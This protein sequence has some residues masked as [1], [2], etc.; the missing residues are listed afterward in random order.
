MFDTVQLYQICILYSVVKF[1]KCMLSIGNGLQTYKMLR[2]L[3]VTSLDVEE[4]I[5]NFVVKKL[6]V[7][8]RVSH[9]C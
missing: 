4:P 1:L 7:D 5:C 9:W 6:A 2:Q 8:W 3:F